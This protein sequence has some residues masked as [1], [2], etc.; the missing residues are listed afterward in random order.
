MGLG[1][2]WDGKPI[3]DLDISIARK[4]IHAAL[5]SGIT[6]FDHA[7]IYKLGK[8]EKV[9][10]TILKENPGLRE[11]IKVQSKAGV[12]LGSAEGYNVYNSSKEHLIGQV[13]QSLKNLSTDY[14]DL[15]LIHRPDPLM[16]PEEIA[17][18]FD[19]LKHE[20]LVRRFG[21]S[22]M[23]SRQIEMLQYYCD[24]PIS[25]NQIQFSLRHAALIEEGVTFNIKGNS[26]NLVADLLSYSKL[27]NV[28]LQAWGALDKGY[29][30]SDTDLPERAKV[31]ALLTKLAE[32]YNTNPAAILIAWILRLPY[33]F[34][35]IIGSINA[36]RIRL[37]AQAIEIN[38]SRE[39]WY[40]IWI[41]VRDKKL[42]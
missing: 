3:S 39:D 7:D 8:A 30:L 1:G 6:V 11:L 37:A 29:Y 12:S 42:P 10:G 27:Q 38:L 5:E 23:S 4:A 26:N 33:S 14:L 19:Y 36:M 13:R 25:V 35:P 18:T 15:F 16:D 17:E 2:A 41:T 31:K 22:N 9:F 32:K 24:M 40:L 34:R 20:G 28:E 21:V